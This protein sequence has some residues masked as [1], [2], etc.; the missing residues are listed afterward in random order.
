MPESASPSRLLP[1]TLRPGE[2]I[3]IVA[4]SGALAPGSLDAAT[5]RLEQAGFRVRCAADVYARRGY[6]SGESD[7]AKAVSL[8]A[9]FADPTIRAVLC[10]KGGYGA[11]RILPLVDWTAVRANPKPFCGFS[12][13]TALH[14][15]LRR[16]TGLVTFHGPMAVWDRDDAQ[17]EW[18]SAGLITAL[19]ATQP[20]GVVA[21]P[22]G[23]TPTATLV[24]GVAEGVLD[25]GN[26][27]M[28]A[29]LCG[30]RWQPRFA[31][32]IVLLE[33]THEAPYRVDRMLTQLVLAGAFADVRGVVFGDSPDCDRPP[34]PRGRTLNEVLLDR[35]G[36]LSVPLLYGFPCGHTAHR[37]TL[38]LGVRARLNATAGTLTLLEPATAGDGG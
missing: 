23:A 13:I 27:S 33:D 28:L 30:T 19:T 11:L 9:A 10:A 26:L 14:Q 16:E 25:G 5:A 18:N 4:P 38:P 37:A 36:P 3:A 32:G 15:A 35:L 22:A 6:L 29:A 7:A 2:T 34:S 1:R 12:D 20:L 21:A 8:S 17:P 24:G 31:D